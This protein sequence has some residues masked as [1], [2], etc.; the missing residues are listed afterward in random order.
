VRDG[1]AAFNADRT[2]AAFNRAFFTLADLP[3]S[4]AKIGTPIGLFREAEAGRSEKVFPEKLLG[5]EVHQIVVS[6]RRLEI[7]ATAMPNEGAFVIVTDLSG[8][9]VGQ[10]KTMETEKS[11]DNPGNG[12]RKAL[13]VD[14]MALVRM[15]TA[16]MLG[17]MGLAAAEAGNGEDALDLL[18]KDNDIDVLVTD[19]GLPGMTG[20]ELIR[21][22]RRRNPSL[23]VVVV[24]GYSRSTA[25]DG[26]IPP[27]ASFL[28]KPFDT[29]Q[30]RRA[31]FRS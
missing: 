12:P 11:G 22:A 9:G 17:E 23:A 15:S 30:L 14:D 2:L 16:D 18:A 4:L 6:D 28:M 27:D 25:N 24:S 20:A 13:V 31:I 29:A 3:P 10:G 21:E 8:R 5:R 26:D 19:L 7:Q 1:V